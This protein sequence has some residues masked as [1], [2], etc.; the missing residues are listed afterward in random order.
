MELRSRKKSRWDNK[1]FS[2]SFETQ[3]VRDRPEGSKRVRG[4]SILW[5]RIIEKDLMKKNQD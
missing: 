2:N 1:M 5:M 4:F 3:Q